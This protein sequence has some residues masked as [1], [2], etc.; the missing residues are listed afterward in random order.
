MAFKC[1]KRFSSTVAIVLSGLRHSCFCCEAHH[2]SLE[3]YCRRL[4]GTSEHSCSLV[5][6]QDIRCIAGIARQL[7]KE[8]IGVKKYHSSS[9]VAVFRLKVIMT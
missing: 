4:N 6:V 5:M 2:N 8:T 7:K 9:A 3:G 1:F